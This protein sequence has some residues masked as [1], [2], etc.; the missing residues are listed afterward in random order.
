MSVASA[1]FLIL[2]FSQPYSGVFTIS[3]QGID[4]M[5]LALIDDSEKDA[6][7]VALPTA[8]PLPA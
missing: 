8:P 6:S 3:S 7:A 4:A 5:L 2:E 1:M